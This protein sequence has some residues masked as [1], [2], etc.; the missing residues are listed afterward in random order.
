MKIDSELE[1]MGFGKPSCDKLI[2]GKTSG[3][4]IEGMRAVKHAIL[5]VE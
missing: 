3:S 5:R 2:I 1:G 4:I